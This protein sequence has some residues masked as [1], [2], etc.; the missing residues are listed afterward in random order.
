[1]RRLRRL[2]GG[3]AA[4]HERGRLVGQDLLR[5]VDLG[6]AERFEAADAAGSPFGVYLPHAGQPRPLLNG[7]EPGEL[8]YVTYRVPDSGPFREFYSRVLGWTFA[9]GHVRD[10]WEVRGTHPM[11]GV[12]GGAPQPVT[13]PMWTVVDVDAAVRRVREAGGTVVAEPSRQSYGV[14]AE[15][16]DDQGGRFYLG[17]DF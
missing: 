14:M 13:T 1:S 15:C 5:L 7:T 17:T 11:A 8:S 10:G 12:A 6:A 3:L 9:P 2:F 16:T 4:V